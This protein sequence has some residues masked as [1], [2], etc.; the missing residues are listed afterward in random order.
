MIG[1][2]L[3]FLLAGIAAFVPVLL[4]A[5]AFSYIEA[6]QGSIRRFALGIFVGSVAVI[7]V[8]F[9][10]E[11]LAMIGLEKYNIF[12]LISR[13][14]SA[15]TGWEALLLLLAI[16]IA[17]ALVLL[18]A[19]RG[20]TSGIRLFFRSVLAS[21]VAS[22]FFPLFWL[23]FL[24]TSNSSVQVSIASATLT[25]FVSITLAYFVV[26][27]VEECGKH[28]SIFSLAS[29]AEIAENAIKF[30]I[31]SALGFAFFENILYFIQAFAAGGGAGIWV[32]RS[33][34]SIGVHIVSAVML[35]VPLAYARK[36][37]VP[38][39]FF[40][41]LGAFF[42]GIFFHAFF[43]I[44]LSFGKMWVIFLYFGIGYLYMTKVL[45]KEV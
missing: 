31:F 45:Y 18:F 8:A 10:Q 26:A 40:A 25:G 9:M 38:V 35:A 11:I 41:L 15:F 23:G 16:I 42:L 14:I 39:K 43:D 12:V 36:S 2:V 3:S 17:I 13:G 30:A 24:G 32:S 33:L 27:L 44:G 22:I 6:E 20:E 19:V 28:L 5:Y 37:G 4:W 7:P 34:F 29:P 21:I 1:E